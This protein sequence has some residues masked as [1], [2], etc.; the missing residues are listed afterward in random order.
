MSGLV[1]W[2]VAH[3]G[4]VS[5]VVV[6]ILDLLFALS[7]S[8]AANGILHQVYLW[9]SGLSSPPAAPS[10]PVTPAVVK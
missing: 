7:P 1:S 4:L 3:Q 9:I 10:A 8:L 6:A 5:G 2:V